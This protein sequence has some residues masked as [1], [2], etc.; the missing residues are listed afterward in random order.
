MPV[1]LIGVLEITDATWPCILGPLIILFTLS[2][3]IPW[4]PLW[5]RNRELS[6]AENKVAQILWGREK[7]DKKAWQSLEENRLLYFILSFFFS[8]S[9]CLHVL[10]LISQLVG[11]QEAPLSPVLLREL[12]LYKMGRKNVVCT[13]CS[14]PWFGFR[15]AAALRLCVWQHKGQQN[16]KASQQVERQKQRSANTAPH[17]LTNLWEKNCSVHW[18]STLRR[19]VEL[20]EVFIDSPEQLRTPREILLSL[21][22]I[23]VYA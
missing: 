2:S 11:S 17:G 6:I 16:W 12:Q 7:K 9:I 18:I 19:Q 21:N 23:R 1:W 20:Q 4:Y 10:A 5:K 14:L 13:N 15:M 22:F 3:V 8:S